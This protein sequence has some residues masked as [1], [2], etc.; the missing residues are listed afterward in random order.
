MDFKLFGV[1]FTMQKVNILIYG[2]NKLSMKIFVGFL[3]SEF[4]E[5]IFYL[6][7]GQKREYINRMICQSYGKC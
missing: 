7:I 2:L 1:L 3:K 5:D 4:A 6:P